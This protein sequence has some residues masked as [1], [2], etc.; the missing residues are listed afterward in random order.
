MTNL[1]TASGDPLP[2]TQTFTFTYGTASL[3]QGTGSLLWESYANLGGSTS[4]SALTGATA[5]PNDPTQTGL[6][7]SFEAPYNTGTTDSGEQL[8][9]YVYPPTTGYYVFTI[10]SDDNGALWLSTNSSPANLTEIAYVASST[11]YRDWSNPNNFEQTSTSIY[12]VANTPY[13]ILAQ[14]KH[15]TDNGD[16]LSVRWEIPATTGGPASTWELNNGVPDSTIPIPGNRLSPPTAAAVQDTTTPPAPAHVRAT[17]TGN[18][19]QI[20]L[21]W[22]AVVG[23]PSGVA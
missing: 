2:A 21:T 19:N 22:N 7:S 6:M 12:L 18:N 17:V 14:Q 13:Y 8:C 16:N 3:T 20:T 23:L 5:Y 4:L 15:G 11:G 1:T 9:G 10:A